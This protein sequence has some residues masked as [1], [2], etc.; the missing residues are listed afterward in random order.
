MSRFCFRKKHTLIYEEEEEKQNTQ[1]SATE[2]ECKLPPHKYHSNRILEARVWMRLRTAL[3]ILSCDQNPWKENSQI[4]ALVIS[5]PPMLPDRRWRIVQQGWKPWTGCVPCRSVC[6]CACV[7]ALGEAPPFSLDMLKHTNTHT[8]TWWL[9]WTGA[10]FK[11]IFPLWLSHPILLQ[12]TPGTRGEGGGRRR[13]KMNIE[14]C[15][16]LFIYFSHYNVWFQTIWCCIS[17]PLSMRR[18]GRR[19]SRSQREREREKKPNNAPFHTLPSIH[20]SDYRGRR[21]SLSLWRMLAVILPC[22]AAS[23]EKR[24]GG[25]EFAFVWSRSHN[26]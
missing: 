16:T 1:S 7:L 17:S 6:V 18:S 20:C 12:F 21:R 5:A 22:A 14:K 9:L 11:Q 15:F 23:W 13:M 2:A 19:R 3:S 26:N 25:G 8:H 10:N 24:G 4:I